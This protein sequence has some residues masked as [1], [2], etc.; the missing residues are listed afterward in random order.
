MLYYK[1]WLESRL[2]FLIA[3]SVMTAYCAVI[4]PLLVL[5]PTLHNTHPRIPM[6]YIVL[7]NTNVYYN[8]PVIIFLVFTVLLG[9]CG[10][11]RERTKGTAAFTLALPVSRVRIVITSAIVGL[12]ETCVL[13]FL[14]MLSIICVSASIH[15]HYPLSQAL[16]FTLL[17]IPCGFVWLSIAFAL[18]SFI[19]DDYLV[20]A[21]A[22]GLF[23]LYLILTLS[24]LHVAAPMN[25]LRIMSGDRMPY[26]NRDSGLLLINALPWRLLSALLLISAALL[27]GSSQ[28]T[29]RQDF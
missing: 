11:P 21:A 25:V 12:I 29:K 6:S 17:W 3:A 18:S 24:P 10:L 19:K 22:I 26:F 23:L 5:L 15:H 7:V 1:L 16:G 4:M 14:P 28:L 27:I 2:R 9:L 20:Q 13:A 8:A